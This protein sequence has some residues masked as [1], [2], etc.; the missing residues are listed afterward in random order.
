MNIAYVFL[1]ESDMQSPLKLLLQLVSVSCNIQ[2]KIT[3]A[4]HGYGFVM[5]YAYPA[6]GDG[7]FV[8]LNKTI[9]CE[10]SASSSRPETDVYNCSIVDANFDRFLEHRDA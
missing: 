4:F 2:A 1:H 9:P 5:L 3:T 10:Q 8:S 7:E 6:G